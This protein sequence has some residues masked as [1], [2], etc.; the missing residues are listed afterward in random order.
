MPAR[1]ALPP[2]HS[3]ACGA[4]K[5]EVNAA[6]HGVVGHCALA[7]SSTMAGRAINICS[8]MG[9]EGAG[10]HAKAAACQTTKAGLCFHSDSPASSSS[11]KRA[12]AGATLL[13]P[14]PHPPLLHTCDAEG[15][16]PV[17]RQL[18]QLGLILHIPEQRGRGASWHLMYRCGCMWL[19]GVASIHTLHGP[20]S[21]LHPALLLQT[22]ERRPPQL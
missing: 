7:C 19:H 12:A 15:L 4:L 5:D 17:L 20:A 14:V 9:R 3:L 6:H 21:R 1:I 2:T 16:A 22:A 8:R 10:A 11:V 13:T 18:I